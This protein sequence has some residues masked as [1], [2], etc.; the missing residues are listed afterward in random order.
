MQFRVAIN[1]SKPLDSARC[2][3]T[4][5]RFGRVRLSLHRASLLLQR[6]DFQCRITVPGKFVVTSR[7]SL[8]EEEEFYKLRPAN[9]TDH[10]CQSWQ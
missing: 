3:D 2:N 4:A 10:L 5:L 1:G 9:K 6:A 7:L 8:E